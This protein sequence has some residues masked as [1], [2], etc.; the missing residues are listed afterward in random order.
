MRADLLALTPDALVSL[1]NA[2]LVKRAQREIEQD[3]GPAVEEA[4]DGT[5][6][7]VFADGVTTS[8]SPGAT[9]KQ[10]TC[11]CGAAGVCRH[12]LAVVLAYQRSEGN[13]SPAE[14]APWSPGEISD[15]ALEALLDATTLAAARQQFAAGLVATVTPGAQPA[16]SL[17]SCTVRFLVK[18]DAAWARCDCKQQQRCAHVALAVWLA[19][20]GEGLVSANATATRVDVSALEQLAAELV[21]TGLSALPPLAVR[22]ATLRAAAA[23]DG[24]VWLETLLE[25]LEQSLDGWRARSARFTTASVRLLVMELWARC[26]A[27]RRGDALPVAWLAGDDAARETL[28]DHVRLVS[29]GCRLERDG[30]TT[31]V[32]VFTADPDTQEVLIFRRRLD[33]VKDSGAELS[34]RTIAPK[35]TLGALARGQL[36]SKVV[37]RHANRLATLSTSRAVMTSVSAQNGDW[38]MFKAPLR[39]TDVKQWQSTEADAPPW[40]LRP[41][42]VAES[43]RVVEVARVLDVI[44]VPAEQAVYALLEDL[45]GNQ[46]EA[47]VRHRAVAPHALLAAARAFSR[48]VRFVS[49]TLRSGARG[50]VLEALAISG[51][52]L[53][54]VPDLG[55]PG[56][57]PALPEAGPD[58]AA[59]AL[60]PV[61]RT[62]ASA[63]DESLVLGKSSAAALQRAAHQC[64]GHGLQH[65]AQRL[66]LAAQGTPSAWLDA[67]LLLDLVSSGLSFTGPLPATQGVRT[68]GALAP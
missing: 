13:A 53:V 26:Q 2:G 17:P 3:K 65:L 62:V 31:F 20:S 55:A 16:V 11:T 29:L 23:K 28:L 54:E 61:L 30:T 42:V 22:F 32:D 50:V 8:I 7:G 35:V 67:A 39:V 12:R 68:S 18:G 63:L 21:T 64:A 41:R 44:S 58:T 38:S 60:A 66:E 59:S 24:H 37:T 15:A 6:R 1:S 36:V 10:A 9:L 45:A 4:A 56:D 57:A 51:D 43:L 49:G 48:P 27:V 14:A 40:F 46:L 52:G 47:V 33:E 19:R 34:R 5:V 25:D